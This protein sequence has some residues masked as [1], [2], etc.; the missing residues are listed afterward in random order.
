MLF[1]V[2]MKV[3]SRNL[4]LPEK[5]DTSTILHFTGVSQ[6]RLKSLRFPLR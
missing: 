1:S 6:E 2:L 3:S 4:S 5:S